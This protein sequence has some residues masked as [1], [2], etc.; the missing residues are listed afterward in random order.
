ML[1]DLGRGADAERAAR[2]LLADVEDGPTLLVLGSVLAERG[3]LG[4]AGPLTPEQ[5]PVLEEASTVLRRAAT[6]DRGAVDVWI[7]HGL[8]L[9]RL[10]HEG[11]ARAAWRAA[12]AL[13]PGRADIE[14]L[15]RGPAPAAP[16]P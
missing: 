16:A 13:A 7:I 8:V 3:G 15:L 4:S 10:G 9:H 1:G 12:R 6:A 2:A 14:E 11:D 5:R